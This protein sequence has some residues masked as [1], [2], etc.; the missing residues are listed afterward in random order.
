[1]K[2]TPTR[3][4][5]RLSHHGTVLSEL[6]RTPGP[7]HSVFDVL[8][9]LAA[10]LTPE[11][12]LGILGFAAG[13]IMAPLRA[14]GFAGP[15]A[16]VDLDP[17]GYTL[18]RHHAASWAGPVTWSQ[19][20]AATWLAQEPA[21]F[22]M[23]IDDLSV[24]AGTDVLKPAITWEVLPRLTREH[25][26]PGGVAVFN[27]LK[28]PGVSWRASLAPLVSLHPAARLVLFQDFENRILV[29]G[30]SLPPAR[31]LGP[32]LRRTLRR[33]GSRQARRIAVR[34]L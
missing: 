8:A 6:R 1:M 9:A 21:D 20:D 26:A 33:L 25:L 18:F 22:A 24:S 5:V 12:R 19:A 29:L 7:T 14:L 2:V 3:N 11:G 15:V 13:G 32:D 30:G 27:L 23:L 17:A 31:V 4:G 16:G 34:S 10:R 28:H